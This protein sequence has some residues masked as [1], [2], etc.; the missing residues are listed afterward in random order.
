MRRRLGEVQ[1]WLNEVLSFKSEYT[2]A[3]TPEDVNQRT[4]EA[5]LLLSNKEYL[6][7]E[8]A[9]LD[10][11]YAGEPK[12]IHHI[13]NLSYILENEPEALHLERVKID[14]ETRC[15]EALKRISEIQARLRL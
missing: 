1:H 3:A 8:A 12:L 4:A 13:L 10:S 14:F 5:R 2:G 6:I 11:E 9:R 15:I 7:K